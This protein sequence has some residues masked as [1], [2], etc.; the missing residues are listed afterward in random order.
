[1]LFLIMHEVTRVIAT[2]ST[3][4]IVTI[5]Q[6]TLLSYS[7]SAYLLDAK[8]KSY[9][10]FIASS[11]RKRQAESNTE[12][13][14]VKSTLFSALKHFSCDYNSNYIFS[15][16][17]FSRVWIC[18]QKMSAFTEWFGFLQ[19]SLLSSFCSL[20]HASILNDEHEIEP[21][22]SQGTDALK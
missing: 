2:S 1:M 10:A 15:P 19:A 8:R 17:C 13:T 5:F 18:G 11:W 14:G 12:T 9:P 6:W 20:T 16:R 3:E 7:S 21:M 22:T 4:Q